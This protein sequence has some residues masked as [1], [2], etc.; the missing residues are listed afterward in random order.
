MTFSIIACDEN[1]GY[2]GIAVASRFFAVGA[3]IPYFGKKCAI[4][5]QALVN[6]M[7]GVEG[8]ALLSDG[9]TPS[10]ALKTLQKSD[11]S[12]SQRQVHM[13]DVSGTTGAHTGCDCIGWAG[14]ICKNGISVAGNMLE[15][16]AVIE[17]MMASYQDN[18]M[19]DF[20]DRLLAAMQA[21]E[22]AGGDKRGRQSASLTIHRGELFPWIDLR[23]DDHDAPLDEIERLL[24]VARERYVFFT[25]FMGT[26]DNFSGIA[27]RTQIDEAIA[28]AAETRFISGRQTASR[29]TEK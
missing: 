29:A 18:S 17:A 20:A 8:I 15:S 3:S 25:E 19:L 24:S 27:D 13:I 28:K 7:W 21:G 22:L 6:P 2:L 26:S 4:A 1:T 5:S 10:N 23:S 16:S 11:K 14:H 12:Q 9:Q